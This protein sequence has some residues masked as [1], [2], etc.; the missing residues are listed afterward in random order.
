[1][2]NNGNGQK[3]VYPRSG[4]TVLVSN[5]KRLLGQGVIPCPVRSTR[6]ELEMLDGV[7]RYIYFFVG[8][9]ENVRALAPWLH[10]GEGFE[11][12]LVEEKDLV[13]FPAVMLDRREHRVWVRRR[14]LRLAYEIVPLIC[15]GVDESVRGLRCLQDSGIPVEFG[16][17]HRDEQ[18]ADQPFQ[19]T[20]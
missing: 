12:P 17:P 7:T 8:L 16:E 9:E 13:T 15:A 4:E 20:R 11:H 2:T 10:V 5:V 18:P 1:M 3:V 6:L 14:E 19:R